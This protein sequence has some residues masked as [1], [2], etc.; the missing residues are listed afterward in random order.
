[1][2]QDLNVGLAAGPQGVTYRTLKC[3]VHVA[4]CMLQ[5]LIWDLLQDLKVSLKDL[6]VPCTCS[7]VYC[8][9]LMSDLLQEFFKCQLQNMLHDPK[10]QHVKMLQ[11]LNEP[12]TCIDAAGPQGVTHM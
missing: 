9:T 12:L 8:R 1:M 11:D 4:I 10:V 7:Y 2:L 6:K 3:H 5:D